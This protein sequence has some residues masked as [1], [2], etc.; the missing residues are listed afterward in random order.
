MFL[1]KYKFPWNFLCIQQF[2]GEISLIEK[3]LNWNQV[4]NILHEALDD[5][6]G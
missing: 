3:S 4:H 1:F 2:Y 6:K 5:F